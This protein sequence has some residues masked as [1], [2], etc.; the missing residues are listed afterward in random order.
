MNLT[1]AFQALDSLN[2]DTFSVDT[3]GIKK[4]QDFVTNDDSVDELSVFDL[5]AED[6]EAAAK[7]CHDGDLI[8]NCS[9]CHSDIYKPADDVV[10]DDE[11]GLACTGMECPYCFST[12]GYKVRP[13]KVVELSDEDKKDVVEDKEDEALEE[14]ID[15]VNVSTDD[16]EIEIQ[17]K[18]ESEEEADE[19][20]EGTEEVTETV[21]LAAK[22]NTVAGILR[23]HMDELSS[24]F[25]PNELRNKVIE[26]VDSSDIADKPVA[27]KLKKALFSKKSVGALLS[28]IATYMTGDKVVKTG[29]YAKA[30]RNESKGKCFK[31]SD[32]EVKQET[33][34]DKLKKYQMWVDYDMEHYG[35]VSETTQKI[36]D[37]A[38]LQLIKDQYGDYEVSV[39]SY[40]AESF[41]GKSV[42]KQCEHRLKEVFYLDEPVHMSA[43]NFND[44]CRD[45]SYLQSLSGAE[46]NDLRNQVVK[47]EFTKAQLINEILSDPTLHGETLDSIERVL[48]QYIDKKSDTI[49]SNESLKE[50]VNSD[51]ISMLDKRSIEEIDGVRYAYDYLTQKDLAE[52]KDIVLKLLRKEFPN[53]T[54]EVYSITLTYD[55][56]SMG[57]LKDDVDFNRGVSIK[58]NRFDYSDNLN[59]VLNNYTP[60]LA[61]E[62]IDEMKATIFDMSTEESLKEDTVKKSN[63]K[64]TNR[65]NSGKEHGGFKTKK[66]ADESCKRK[67]IK[68]DM[69]KFDVNIPGFKSEIVDTFEDEGYIGHM[70]VFSKNGVDIVNAEI[71]EDPTAPIMIEDN[72]Y[73]PNLMNRIYDSFESFAEDL[74]MKARNIAESKR[75]LKRRSIKED[76]EEIEIKSDDMNIKIEPAEEEE[77]DTCSEETVKPLSDEE[78]EEIE[79]NVDSVDKETFNEIG[80]NFLKEN[81]ENVKFFR[82]GKIHVH[83][84]KFLVEGIIGFKN[85]KKKLTQFTF[86]P[87]F[88]K[89]GKVRFLGENFDISSKRKSLSLSG[90]VRRGTLISESLRRYK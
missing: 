78:K 36:I 88:S 76:V 73:A 5:D 33:I 26:I 57:V 23:Q 17:D 72:L 40:K 68:E 21:D 49:S 48:N 79:L 20:D 56:L 77:C 66:E 82:T 52:V 9:V 1:E 55:E 87:Q 35:K 19:I 16:V 47:G 42:K 24:I 83:N 25:D 43:K 7:N 62:L 2:E 3:E 46:F 10:V 50:S 28:T 14:D 39:G 12:D 54:F 45:N 90:K 51:I 70:V 59:K 80:E 84:N 30:A 6:D 71:W 81:Y 29:K 44:M 11:T 4:L 13:F 58:L 32:E 22:D 27:D 61:H 18:E 86:K 8:L 15:E 31:E 41:V 64:W 37:E 74:T 89:N 60:Q 65:G 67:S 38:G 53:S 75:S 63:G 69:S 85:G 34:G